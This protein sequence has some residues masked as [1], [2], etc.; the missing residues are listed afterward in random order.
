MQKKMHSPFTGAGSQGRGCAFSSIGRKPAA[1][2]RRRA[3]ESS[4]HVWKQRR[5][6]KNGSPFVGA[7]TQRKDGRPDEKDTGIFYD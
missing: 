4:W 7:G 3:P 1:R 2:R 5:K 6:Y